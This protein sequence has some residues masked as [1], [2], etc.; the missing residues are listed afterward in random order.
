MLK[1]IIK[2]TAK[3]VQLQ[4]RA[5]LAQELQC[6]EEQDGSLLQEGAKPPEDLLGGGMGLDLAGAGR[7]RCVCRNTALGFPSLVSHQAGEKP[8]RWLL[9]GV[10]PGRSPG[11]P[12]A[13]QAPAAVLLQALGHHHTLLPAQINCRDVL[14]W[15]EPWFCIFRRGITK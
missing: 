4:R 11:P 13:L 14:V 5:V 15:H 2:L 9:C 8:L 12:A 3:T 1:L 6:H 7:E 10:V